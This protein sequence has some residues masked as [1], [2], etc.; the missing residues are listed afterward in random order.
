MRNKPYLYISVALITV[1]IVIVA[2]AIYVLRADRRLPNG[3]YEDFIV[4]CVDTGEEVATDPED[5]G[6][7]SWQSTKRV[8]QCRATSLDGSQVV[9]LN[10][11][12]DEA[13]HAMSISSGCENAGYKMVADI[14]LDDSEY[15]VI[16][17]ATW[18]EVFECTKF[19]EQD[20]V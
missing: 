15:D 18:G 3:I 5:M 13:L 10:L 11:E 12:I 8:F 9:D 1:I 2:V 6:T 16:L 19:E 7:H 4:T 17:D 14:E 20:S